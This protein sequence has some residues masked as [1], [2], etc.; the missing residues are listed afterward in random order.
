MPDE[1]IE[2]IKSTIKGLLPWFEIN[3]T[4]QVVEHTE[5]TPKSYLGQFHLFPITE[6]TISND[7]EDV[8]KFINERY[9]NVLVASYKA[10]LTVMT[11]ITGKK[12][13]IQIYLGFLT[14]KDKDPYVFQKII[15]GVLPGI[16]TQYKETLNLRQLIQNQEYGGIV[17]GIPTLKIDDERQK[18]NISSVIRSMYGENYTLV[19]ISKPVEQ[20]T[21]V[22]QFKEILD[23]RD[24]CHRIAN[25]T[26]SI[27]GGG[28]NSDQ[29]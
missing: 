6:L 27:E 28:S 2:T 15:E 8:A 12:G 9:L 24:S 17:S 23:I 14:D 21:A 22:Q 4:S 13:K 11:A 16:K 25:Q 20:S 5:K 1:R 19:I 26:R 18:F 7:V 29:K 10:G 3:E